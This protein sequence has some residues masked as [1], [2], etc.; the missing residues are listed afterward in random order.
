MRFV[1]HWK[2][3]FKAE[4]G[5]AQDQPNLV[6]LASDNQICLLSSHEALR[7]QNRLLAQQLVRNW[8]LGHESIVAAVTREQL[9]AGP[10]SKMD[11]AFWRSFNPERSGDVLFALA[12]YHV[13]GGAGAT[14]GSPWTY[15]THVPLLFL[16]GGEGLS[17]VPTGRFSRPSSPAMI[18]PTL[19][20][21][22]RVESPAT[23]VEEALPEFDSAEVR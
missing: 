19:A 13:Q 20:A 21:L 2:R 16:P 8:L 18:A 12:P 1:L 15:D 3:T 14:H 6:Q 11:Q 9:L 17:N 7:G 5:V 10:T 23:C 22:L 4:L